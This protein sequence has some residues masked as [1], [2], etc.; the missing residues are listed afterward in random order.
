MGKT[1]FTARCGSCHN[2]NRIL[3]G[4]A[5]AGVDQ[6][7]SIEWIVS[8]VHSS[9][10]VIKGGDKIATALFEKFNKMQMPDHPDLSKNDITSIVDYIKSQ[11][12]ATASIDKDP[13]EKPSMLHPAYLPLSLSNYGFFLGFFIIVALLILTLLFFVRVK[14]YE[15]KMYYEK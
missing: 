14:E 6:R 15:R 13:F 10:T 2:I 8:F 3:V 12:N 5:L 11:G 9:Q 7:H 4:P 1:I